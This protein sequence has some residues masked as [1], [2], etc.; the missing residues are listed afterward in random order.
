MALYTNNRYGK[1]DSGTSSD[2]FK[3]LKPRKK[4]KNL[5]NHIN[6]STKKSIQK[7]A[8]EKLVDSSDKVKTPRKGYHVMPNGKLMKGLKHNKLQKEYGY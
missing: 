6:P 4:F 2:L 7:T 1:K 3:F 8:L 5:P